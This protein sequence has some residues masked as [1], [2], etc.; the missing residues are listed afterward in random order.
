MLLLRRNSCGEWSKS[1]T[2]SYTTAKHSNNNSSK[3]I[4]KG[5][6]SRLRLTSPHPTH[7]NVLEKG[8]QTTM[9]FKATAVPIPSRL[10]KVPFC[11]FLLPILPI[12]WRHIDAFHTVLFK[13][14]VIDIVTFRIAPRYRQRR[15]AAHF[16]EHVLCCPRSESIHFEIFFALEALERGFF[17]DETLET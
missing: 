6:K 9:R 15:D 1:L 11:N 7:S 17:D 2:A 3:T 16:A 10:P 5:Y 8:L 14:P 13:A 4:P 12:P